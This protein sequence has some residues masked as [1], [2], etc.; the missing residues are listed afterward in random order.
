MYKVAIWTLLAEE[1]R[2]MLIPRAHVLW[3]YPDICRDVT[4]NECLD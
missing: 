1:F 2:D 4:Q 3:A